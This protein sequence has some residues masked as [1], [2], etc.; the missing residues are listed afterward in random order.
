MQ[1]FITESPLGFLE[2]PLRKYNENPFGDYAVRK[3]FFEFLKEN[4]HG[5]YNIKSLG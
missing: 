1:D 5:K 4:P 3:S 2:S